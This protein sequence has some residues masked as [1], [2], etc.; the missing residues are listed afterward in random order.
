VC[1]GSGVWAEQRGGREFTCGNATAWVGRGVLPSHDSLLDWAAKVGAWSRDG[2]DSK[3]IKRYFVLP[4]FAT[5]LLSCQL[6]GQ[7]PDFV[8]VT[9]LTGQQILSVNTTLSRPTVTPIF[10]LAGS[11]F[12]GIVYGPEGTDIASQTGLT[13]NNIYVCDPTEDT[14]YRVTLA[15]SSGQ[16]TVT[17]TYAV[18]YN[19]KGDTSGSLHQ[20]Q[21]GRFTSTGDFLVTSKTRGGV[22][23]F[24]GLAGAATFPTPRQ[25][26]SGSDAEGD[27][28][29]ANNSDL[30]IVDLASKSVLRSTDF[31]TASGFIT[32]NLTQPTGGIARRN[33]GEIYVADGGG[34]NNIK[35]FTSDG[36]P[37]SLNSV[38]GT[39]NDVP[40]FIKVAAD[41]TLYVATSHAAGN[42][43]NNG[44]LYKVDTSSCV[45]SLVAD[46]GQS[47]NPPAIGVAIPPTSTSKTKPP[48]TTGSQNFN[49]GFSQFVASNVGSCN[50]PVTVKEFQRRRGD[51]K[52]LTPSGTT[53][54][55]FLGEGG[56]YTQFA[57]PHTTCIPSSGSLFDF[58]LAGF[59]FTSGVSTNP[60]IV[61][62]PDDAT[63]FTQCE[64]GLNGFFPVSEAIPG[65][66]CILKKPGGGSTFFV[67]NQEIGNTTATFCG[68]QSPL[69]NGLT[70][71]ADPL[72]PSV[73]TITGKTLPIKF[74]ISK[75]TKCSSTKTSD[76]I[77]DASELLSLIRVRDAAGNVTNDIVTPVSSTSTYSNPCAADFGP[78]AI[79]VENGNKQYSFSLSLNALKPGVWNLSVTSLSNNINVQW[80]YF[81]IQ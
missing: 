46:I 6:W 8:L 41:G 17:T 9:D 33:D 11:N 37:D 21:C 47:G 81:R 57:F 2:E 24:A 73:P 44:K 26:V 65:D 72:N 45:T 3:V 79:C 34:Q 39:F 20:A 49:F 78:T 75:T 15:V 62:C 70:N 76:Y 61:E 35:A 56:F 55:P 28:T 19:G 36:N 71:N 68:F 54:Q 1:A 25:I 4:L 32:T 43:F 69:N 77:T 60:R 64:I 53:I 23:K 31:A 10:T 14:I 22:W 40:E 27:L 63:S 29:Q 38:C 16:P 66:C 12:E 5:L 13:N 42:G 7:N 30:L 48:I 18:V 51:L 52:S 59:I 58:A 67:V 80:N 50:G 74:T